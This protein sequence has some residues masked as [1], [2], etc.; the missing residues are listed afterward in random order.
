M[1]RDLKKHRDIQ[2][3]WVKNNPQKA[4]A[5]QDRYKKANWELSMLRAA[6]A[7]AAKMNREFSLELED[8]IIPEYCPY[9]NVPLTRECRKENNKHNPSIDRID[10]SKGYLRGNIRV[11]SFKAN[12]MKS[13]F[14]NQELV[15]IA[16]NILSLHKET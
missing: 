3:Q 2:K 13:D 10:P 5:I 15:T 16:N 7:N 8:I 1:S 4:Q 6:K 12:R 14:S 11:I 9:L